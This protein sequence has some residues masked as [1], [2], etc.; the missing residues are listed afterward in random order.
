MRSFKVPLRL[1]LTV[2]AMAIP[3]AAFAVEQYP[4]LVCNGFYGCGAPAG[5]VLLLSTLPTAAVLLMQLAAGGAVV[6]IVIAGTQMTISYGDDAVITSARKAI[7]FALGGFGLALTSASIV[8]FV[9]TENYGFVGGNVVTVMASVVRI[10]LTLFNVGFAIVIILAGLRM[11]T[12]QGN[13]DEF[14]KGGAMIKWA[15]IGGVVVNI[16]KVG[17]QAFLALNL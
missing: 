1:I 3:A 14:K 10:I 16:A 13:A 4:P 6:A 7:L 9:T 12:A 17:I 11:I 8:T 2:I 15:I 5:N